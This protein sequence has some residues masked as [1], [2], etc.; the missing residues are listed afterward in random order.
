MSTETTLFCFATFWDLAGHFSSSK[1]D[2]SISSCCTL[3]SSLVPAKYAKK[4]P[5]TYVQQVEKHTG[6]KNLSNSE[7][8]IQVIYSHT[9]LNISRKLCIPFHLGDLQKFQS[10]DILIITW[11]H[12]HEPLSTG[13][14]H[15]QYGGNPFQYTELPHH[16]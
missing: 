3:H 8:C 10:D 5:Y 2:P 16:H 9:Y 7:E 6:D 15:R 11:L 1:L 14:H 4:S 12:V 13:H